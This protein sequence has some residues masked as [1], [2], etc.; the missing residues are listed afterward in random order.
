MVLF[1]DETEKEMDALN[2]KGWDEP[3]DEPE[4]LPTTRKIT[5]KQESK[6]SSAKDPEVQLMY[7]P[8]VVSHE[9]ALNIL[10]DSS[11]KMNEA[12]A[13]IQS[14]LKKIEKELKGR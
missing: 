9:E 3:D 4:E 13:Q 1:D 6:A 8:R 5:A 2:P 10:L 12:L 14:D 7:V 11:Q